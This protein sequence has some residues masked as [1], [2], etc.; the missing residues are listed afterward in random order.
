MDENN[1]L[2]IRIY[3]PVK[4]AIFLPELKQPEL[5]REKNRCLT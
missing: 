5:K 4:G 1:I 3:R 2:I